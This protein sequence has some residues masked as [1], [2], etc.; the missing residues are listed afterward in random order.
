[1]NGAA[2]SSACS[3]TLDCLALMCICFNYCQFIS[4][5]VNTGDCSIDS[6][7]LYVYTLCG[8]NVC[9]YVLLKLEKCRLAEKIQD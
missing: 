4:Y 3:E 8:K 1:M 5:L 9:N 2:S 6:R 7:I